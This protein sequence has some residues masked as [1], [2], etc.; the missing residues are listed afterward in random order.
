MIRYLEVVMIG[1]EYVEDKLGSKAVRG[2]EMVSLAV[3]LL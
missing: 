2:T 3:Q 1:I